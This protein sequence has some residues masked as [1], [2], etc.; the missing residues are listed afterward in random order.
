MSYPTAKRI[1]R[2][3]RIELDVARKVRA[4][5]DGTLD[6]CDAS[7]STDKWARDCYHLP[8]QLQRAVRNDHLECQR[9]C[10]Y[11]ICAAVTPN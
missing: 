8:G 6:P 9:N 4:V 2:E 7:E 5:M 1:A 10:R 3:L 11:E